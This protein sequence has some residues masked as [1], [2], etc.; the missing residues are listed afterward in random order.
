MR[1]GSRAG[2]AVTLSLLAV[3]CLS[4]LQP[5]SGQPGQWRAINPVFGNLNG[6]W[7][8]SSSSGWA[9]GDGGAIV[10]WDGTKW[11][12]VASPAPATGKLESVSCFSATN[13]WA[14][15]PD[16][17]DADSLAEI[18]YWDG[19]G[20]TDRSASL[21]AGIIDLHSIW[22]RPDG[23]GYAVGKSTGAAG[24][25]I[26]RLVV[27]PLPFVIASEVNLNAGADEFFSIH[28]LSSGGPSFGFV[29]GKGGVSY[30]LDLIGAPG[31]WTSRPS[32]TGN[33]LLGVGMISGTSAFAVGKLDTRL[34]WAG[35]PNWSVDGGAV[36]PTLDWR[37][38]SLISSSEGWIV[39]TAGLTTSTLARRGATGYTLLT[40]S[41]PTTVK[42]NSVQMLSAAD[43][44]AVGDGGAVIRWNG[45]VWTALTSPTPN[46]IRGV[47]LA[48]TADGWA[49]GDA[50][51]IL[52]WNGAG[53]NFYQTS[54]VATQLNEIHGSSS[55]QIWAVGNDPDGVGAVP[56]VTIRWSG[57]PAWT[58]VSPAG[59][60][61]NV[62]LEGV[63][64]IS[65]TLALAVGGA[66]GAAALI[67]W[68]GAI[69]GSI[70]P[71]TTNKLFSTWWVSSTEGWAVGASGTVVHC[72]GAGPVCATETSGVSAQ[73]NGVQAL[74]STNVWAVGS[75]GTI[76][77]RDGTGWSTVASGLGAGDHLN[78]LYMVSAT[79][80]WAVGTVSGGSPVI[81][82]WDGSTWSRVYPTPAAIPNA[83]EDVWMVASLDG[84][85]V[86]QNGLILR[87]AAG[88]VTSVTTIPVTVTSTATSTQSV[89][90]TST[91]A[92]S[93]VSTQVTSTQSVSTT[94]TYVST[95]SVT[96][97]GT[98]TVIPP[99]SP[100]PGFPMESIL[101]GLFAGT[102]ALFVLRRR[103]RT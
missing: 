58:D 17:A 16:D 1:I 49:V 6:V 7:M 91:V 8:I 57:G 18:Y 92:T 83:L 28:L 48:S 22:I 79:E 35:G 54:P 76:I 96:T 60:A 73:L 30:S 40:S 63:F 55:G 68:D 12:P 38:I 25:N 99:P 61:N 47:W 103:R 56:P 26:I 82:Y 45:S 97:T 43:G 4:L 36:A 24:F 81:L 11:N 33:D 9:V 89:T 93:T 46:D 31:T 51:T 21:P 84:W 39:G 3:I 80:G 65:P 20:W 42:L 59:V 34:T 62:D 72:T 19:T 102:A 70:A 29:V 74:T 32:G 27:N 64:T 14:V 95:S 100:I 90:V 10:R 23:L 66:A 98:M 53:W 69:W 94:T 77:H 101:A 67:K 78:S 87:F 44:F 37:G 71:G 2:L 86:G 13:C 88:A 85:A 41:V 52:R 50:G 15:G 75:G 5:V